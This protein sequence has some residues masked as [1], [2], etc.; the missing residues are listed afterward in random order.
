M[1]R[2]AFFSLPLHTRPFVLAALLLP[3]AAASQAALPKAPGARVVTVS[4]LGRE[5]PSIAVNPHS[6][7]Q[8]LAVFQGPAEAA[9]SQDSARTFAPASGTA[10]PDWRRTGECR[11]PSIRRA[12]H[13]CAT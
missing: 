10:A 9:Y 5:E 13:T 3:A 6:P 2:G 7:N 11:S 12:S 4:P 1:T 8:V